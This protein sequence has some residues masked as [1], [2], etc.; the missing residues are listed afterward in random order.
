MSPL[1]T[2]C[3]QWSACSLKYWLCFSWLKH[4]TN[5]DASHGS[6]GR[7]VTAKRGHR[8]WPE[9][10]TFATNFEQTCSDFSNL[11]CALKQECCSDLHKI[12]QRIVS[13]LLF[14]SWIYLRTHLFGITVSAILFV[15]ALLCHH[16]VLFECDRFPHIE[17]T[18]LCLRR[19]NKWGVVVV[20]GGIAG[21]GAWRGRDTKR[22]WRAKTR[23]VL[24]KAAALHHKNNKW[25]LSLLLWSQ[26]EGRNISRGRSP[27]L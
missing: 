26:S 9:W 14:I 19:A 1:T 4:K 2:T 18:Q 23:A 13:P 24:S 5:G 20:V 7:M 21:V 27:H 11:P 12:M 10:L 17:K 8:V 15:V 25:R 16:F 22:R 3:T 6:K